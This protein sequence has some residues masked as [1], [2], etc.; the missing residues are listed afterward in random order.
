MGVIV[1]KDGRIELN[2]QIHEIQER[3]FIK[4][5]IS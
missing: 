1:Y 5:L 3:L 4:P 2:K